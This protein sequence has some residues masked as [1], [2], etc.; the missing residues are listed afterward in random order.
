MT[1]HQCGIFR[2]LYV[3]KVQIIKIKKSMNEFG[4]KKKVIREIDSFVN[5]ILSL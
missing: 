3:V 2:M 5:V 4:K 1:N